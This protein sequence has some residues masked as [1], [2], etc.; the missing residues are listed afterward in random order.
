M[1]FQ[2][3]K[4][5]WEDVVFYVLSVL[6]YLCRIIWVWFSFWRS[7]RYKMVLVYDMVWNCW[8]LFFCFIIVV[9]DRFSERKQVQNWNFQICVFVVEVGGVCDF[10]K[11][12]I[13]LF[14]IFL[15]VW[16]RIDIRITVQERFGL[17]LVLVFGWFLALFLVVWV[18]ISFRVQLI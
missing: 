13:Y 9:C 18:S 1:S 14:N 5:I 11:F 8:R 6:Y 2:M 12:V 16:F 15:S 4:R 7:C 10:R 3:R 17:I